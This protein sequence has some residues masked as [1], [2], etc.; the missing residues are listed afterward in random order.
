MKRAHATHAVIFDLDGT[1]MDSLPLVLRALQHAVEPYGP[2]VTKDIFK[3]LGGPPDSFLGSLIRDEKDLPAAMLRLARFHRDNGHLIEPF[4]GV[5]ALLAEL[6][7]KSI[8]VAL[9]TGR[10]RASLE[11]LLHAHNFKEYFATVVAGDDLATHKPEPEGLVEIL[12]RLGVA[13]HEAVMVGDADVDVQGAAAA[14]V[15]A[16]MI[17]HGRDVDE[18]VAKL[19]WRIAA[20]PAEA[21][22]WVRELVAAQS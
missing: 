19:A 6:H 7:A 2:P 3:T 15:D 5:A 10:D 22:G 20:S 12:R 21:Y 11:P 4:D 18:S 17:H 9:W 1:L 14:G 16:I 8:A 13:P